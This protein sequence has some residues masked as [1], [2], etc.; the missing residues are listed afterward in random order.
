MGMSADQTIPIM[1]SLGDALFGI[2]HG[3]EAEMKSVVDQIGKIKVAGVATWGD[4]SQLQT[5]GIDALGAMSLATGKTK[6][7]LRDLAGSGGIPAKEAI[8]ALT[9]GIEMN[10][11]YQGGMAKQSASL[12]GILSTLSGYPYSGNYGKMRGEQK[13]HQRKEKEPPHEEE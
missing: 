13:P 10:P 8:D 11:L 2:G 12:S 7:S 5:H 1:T 4:I 6:E 9:K 3:T